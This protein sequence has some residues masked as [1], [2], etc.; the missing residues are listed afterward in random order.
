ML[1]NQH[2]DLINHLLIILAFFSIISLNCN[3]LKK[4]SYGSE[5][6]TGINIS[7]ITSDEI[8]LNSKIFI[9]EKDKT[10]IILKTGVS[11][12]TI[13]IPSG[14]YD[15]RIVCRDKIKW[16]K[17]IEVKDTEILSRIVVIPNSKIIIHCIDDNENAISLPVNVY[18]SDMYNKPVNCGWSDEIIDVPPGSYDIEIFRKGDS[19]FIK[20]IYLEDGETYKK[21]EIIPHK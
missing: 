17:D 11:G 6:I 10:D 21:T 2:K 12:T 16:L 8:P 20:D 14:N 1:K 7:T 13:Q 15:I 5:E 9:T 18:E 3:D 19:F 4:E